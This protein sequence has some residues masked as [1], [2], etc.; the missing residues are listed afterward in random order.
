MAQ[1]EMRVSLAFTANTNE[2]I[3]QIKRLQKELNELATGKSV[4]KGSGISQ[5]TPEIQKAMVAAGELQAKLEGAVNLKTGKLDLGVFSDSLKKSGV[6]LQEYASKLNALGPQGRQAFQ[7]LAQSIIQAEAPLIRC[8]QKLKEFG[9]S[10]A[11]TARWQISSSILHGFIGSV[12]SAYGYVKNLNASLNDIRIVTGASVEEMA[13]FADKAN[14]AARALSTTTNEYAKASLIYFQ[15]GLSDEEVAK[16]TEVTVKMANAAGKTAEVVSD[17]LTAVWNNFYDG[18][19]SLEHYADVMTALGAAT[20]SSTDE[21]AGGLEKFAAVAETIGLSYEYAASALATI[22]S[23]TRQSEEVVGTALRTIFARIQGLKLGEVL[24]DGTTLNKY[25]E[26]LDK[27][28][29]SIFDQSG[30]IK[31]MDNILDEMADKWVKLNKDQQLALAQTVAG[32]RQYNQL[33]SLMD[34][35]D[36]GDSDSMVAN[37]E[38]AANSSGELQKQADIYA[39]SWEAAR[40][41]VTAAA[42]NI[43]EKILD[44]DFFI[45]FLGGLENAIDGVGNLIDAFGGL[46]GVLFTVGAYITRIYQ[47]EIA[48][49]MR[50]TATN[51]KNFLPIGRQEQQKQ[52]EEAVESLGMLHSTTGG[53]EGEAENA[54]LNR[55]V[56]MQKKLLSVAKNISAEDLKQLQ[57]QM[58]QVRT[59]DKQAIAAGKAADAIEEE[60]EDA[61]ELARAYEQIRARNEKRAEEQKSGKTEAIVK[62]EASQNKRVEIMEQAEAASHMSEK[63]REKDSRQKYLADKYNSA[64]TNV[65][66]G[67]AK[68]IE[69]EFFRI[70][71]SDEEVGQSIIEEIRIAKE[72]AVEKYKSDLKQSIDNAGKEASEKLKNKQDI[73]DKAAMTKVRAK[74]LQKSAEGFKKS[75]S[76]NS[77]ENNVEIIEILKKKIKETREEAQKLNDSLDEESP[78]LTE[79][80]KDLK[81]LE[82]QLDK[83]NGEAENLRKI[84]DQLSNVEDDSVTEGVSNIASNESLK[85]N[86]EQRASDENKEA[87][88]Q[89]AIQEQQQAERFARARL[90]AEQEKDN[91][92]RA[93]KG[94][95]KSFK[96]KANISDWADQ[97]SDTTNVVMS[98]SSILTSAQ[99]IVDVFNNPDASGWDKV[100]ALMSGV[101]GIAPA[102]STGLNMI[103]K[104]GQ[105]AGTGLVAAFGS[106]GL[107]IMG[108]VT[109]ITAVVAVV[110]IVKNSTVSAE[111]KIQ[112]LTQSIDSLKES[113]SQAEQAAQNLKDAL[114]GF[115]EAYSTLENCVVGTTEWKTAMEDVKTSI[116]NILETYPELKQIKDIVKWDEATQSYILNTEEVEKQIEQQENAAK[117]FQYAADSQKGHLLEEQAEGYKNDFEKKLY[118]ST[119]SSSGLGEQ[120]FGILDFTG[121][122]AIDKENILNQ[123]KSNLTG[124][125]SGKDLADW[126]ANFLSLYGKLIEELSALAQTYHE[127]N[128]EANNVYSQASKL[129][130]Q[131]RYSDRENMSQAEINAAAQLQRKKEIDEYSRLYGTD[132]TDGDLENLFD[133]ADG[134]YE[135]LTTKQREFLDLYEEALGKGPIT[136]AENAIQG[137]DANRTF[138]IEGQE[139]ISLEDMAAT[140][141][142]YLARTSKSEDGEDDYLKVMDAVD[143]AQKSANDFGDSFIDAIAEGGTE[144]SLSN[145]FGQLTG[146]ELNKFKN[147]F[148]D[149]GQLDEEALKGMDLSIEE[150]QNILHL[151]GID[152]AIFGANVQAAASKVDNF[153]IEQQ[154]AL[155]ASK[156]NK[157]NL[158]YQE[159]K[160]FANNRIAAVGNLKEETNGNFGFYDLWDIEEANADNVVGLTK[161]YEGISV[162]DLNAEDAAEQISELAEQHGIETDSIKGLIDEVN[163]LD[164]VY[165]ISTTDIQQQAAKLKDVVG[166]GLEV[167]DILDEEQITVLKEAG[168]NVDEYFSQMSDG[169]YSLT[170]KAEEFNKIVNDI[171]LDGLLKKLENFNK[172]QDQIKGDYSEFVISK[173][174]NENFVGGQDF[175]KARLDYITALGGPESFGITGEQKELYDSYI[176]DPTQ[177]FNS[178]QLEMIAEMMGIV[179]DYAANLESQAFL[180][181]NSLQELGTIAVEVGSYSLQSYADGLINIASQYENCSDEIVNY[182]NALS[183]GNLKLIESSQESLEASIMLGEA[184]EKYG[185]ELDELNIQSEQLAKQYN[186]TAKEASE[187]AVQNQRMNKGVSTLHENWKDWSK[188]LKKSDKTTQDW[189]KAASETTKAI[190]DLVGTSEDLELPPEFFDSAENMELV[191]QAAKGNEDA[192][193]KLGLAVAAAQVQMIEFQNGMRDENGFLVGE[194]AFNRWKDTVSEGITNLQNELSG[195]SI[196][197]NVYEQLGGD[198]WVH[199]L[200]EMAMATGMSVE[201]MNSMLNSMGVQTEVSTTTK[202]VDM[203]VPWYRTEETVSQDGDKTV[204]ESHI[205]EQGLDTINGEIEVAQINTGDSIGSKPKITY[206]GNGN[207][208]SSATK[209]SGSGS[210]SGSTKSPDDYKKDSIVERYKEINDALDDTSQRLEEASDEADRLWGSARIAAMKKA[211]KEL[212]EEISLLKEKRGQINTY[213]RTDKTALNSAAKKVGVKFTYDEDGDI[214][215]YTKEVLALEKRRDSLIAGF[216]S[217]IDEN[218]QKEID[219]LDKN[220]EEFEK[221]YKKYEDTKKERDENEKN[222]REKE[223][224]ER[225]KNYEI[226]TQKIEYKIDIDDRELTELDFKLKVIEDDFF[227]LGESMALLGDKMETSFNSLETYGQ[228]QAEIDKLL[229]KGKIDPADWAEYTKQNYDNIYNA[230]SDIVD[231]D[232]EMKEY[233]GNTLDKANEEISKYTDRMEHQTAVL[234]H[235]QSVME[236]MGKSTDY[237]KMGTILKGQSQTLKDQVAVAERTMNIFKDQ[238]ADWKKKYEKALKSGNKEQIEYYKTQYEEAIKHSTEAEENYLSKVESYAESVKAVFENTLSE[239]GQDLENALTGG[240]SFDQINSNLERAASI[241]EEYLT[242]TNQIYETNKLMRS[243][244]QEIDK[245][246]NTIAKNRLKEFITQTNQMQNQNKL[247]QFELD[248]QQAKYDLLLAE[249][250]LEEAQNAKSMVRLQRDSEGNFGYVYT[251]DSEKTSQAEQAVADAENKLYNIQLDGANSYTEKY[252]QTM[253]EMYDTLTDL[254]TQYLEGAFESE[255]EYRNAVDSATKYYYDKLEQYSSLHAVAIADDSR[256]VEDAWSTSFNSMIYNTENW[257]DSVEEYVGNVEKAFKDFGS[258][259]KN[260]EKDLGLNKIEKSVSNITKESSKLK[261]ELTKKDGVLDAV[262]KEIKQVNKSATAYG[263]KRKEIVDTAKAYQ[264]LATQIK[265][266]LKQKS[267]LDKTKDD[268]KEK[269]KDDKTKNKNQNNNKDNNNNNDSNSSSGSK[270]HNATTKRGVA[271]AIW[272]G[273]YGW[274]TGETR[275]DRLKEKGFDPSEIQSLVNN[276][277]VAGNWQS[278]YGIS[279]LSKYS[280]QSFDTGGYTGAWGP[281]GKL[282]LLHE[283]EIVLDKEDTENFLKGIYAL[284]DISQNGAYGKFL[285][286]YKEESNVIENFMSKNSSLNTDLLDQIIKSIDLFTASNF[287]ASDL[288]IPGLDNEINKTLDQK[289][290][291]SATFPNVT[292]HSEIEE[293]FENLRNRASQYANRD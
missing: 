54:A 174:E 62:K 42:E 232:K 82:G 162:L 159:K 253:S 181:A 226:F 132:G 102:V 127:V 240:T 222:I 213:L 243:A 11:N 86:S 2:A 291:I 289:V 169:T 90:K 191:S 217:S 68:N 105:R 79:K 14:K 249:I 122:V 257:K 266:T 16:R 61:R 118:S 202:K 133:R 17:Q 172:A 5:L 43:Y 238:E 24:D 292:S 69:Q 230:L 113:S 206:V 152:L 40:D 84:L 155:T 109:A 51:I 97:I 60:L 180:T 110:S 182:Q 87:A 255:E 29:I 186:L 171:P 280:Y 26:A 4:L 248:I 220:I 67:K 134:S 47:K 15:Q 282:A 125:M 215:N 170:G 7:S 288:R 164:K 173:L 265:N 106:V 261:T 116:D 161:F 120:Q 223:N 136:W 252:Q 189:A 100:M 117:T 267:K 278:R 119:L 53:R 12:Q 194:M 27:V 242:T 56:D 124:P 36:A 245:T 228:S 209:S 251:A 219:K 145:F 25:S 74:D 33:I 187:L 140:V 93:Q 123:A 260:I 229:E 107:T 188:E 205:V 254:Q 247:S 103:E 227:S 41:R 23:N 236:I 283:K 160:D 10:L 130:I 293:A 121:N 218:E 224:E 95:D 211:N 44:D 281:A 80:I 108:I 78:E 8:N 59:M 208:S 18:S 262:E 204:R 115:D 104:A 32:T 272:N 135:D 101:A 99:G 71:S 221:A 284:R 154:S 19:K 89:R 143:L 175:A 144:E 179:N 146:D 210:G 287:I 137:N 3:Q 151:L 114:T 138:H 244:Q 70:L 22:T 46:K 128:Q 141:S 274:G 197:D 64:N 263:K 198:D 285:S 259:M 83:S 147:I 75:V 264:S 214:I 235:Y 131:E 256:V 178:D 156:V 55:E 52:K 290:E 30:E 195:L 58:D 200:N 190:A 21:I 34:N 158:T 203:K 279:D 150:V 91:A 129:D 6:T 157:S 28:G 276:T 277:N 225:E 183:S 77:K 38:T 286:T 176:S 185:L 126:E 31:N 35:W 1:N 65:K 246:N 48:Q 165:N 193:N 66:N 111:E 149:E 239:F 258:E 63:D 231:Y 85:I 207:V 196:G 142:S 268:D 269:N 212:K 177:N 201:E 148:N 49:G 88:E 270:S 72:Q 275:K 234:E 9:V 45:D 92:D 163:S 273:G 50:N 184:S 271:L 39:E 199:A 112:R 94:L 81:E 20:A 73:T 139:P 241:Q 153:T 250:A 237:K 76:E 192:I 37:L 168:I 57:I 233:Y 216:G 167:G 96:N 13:A 98:F 166:D